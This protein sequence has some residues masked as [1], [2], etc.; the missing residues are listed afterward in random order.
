MKFYEQ[1]ITNK[2]IIALRRNK[3]SSLAIQG[4]EYQLPEI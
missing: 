1:E 2:R 4:A 3:T